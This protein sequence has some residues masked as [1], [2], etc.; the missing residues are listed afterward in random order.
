MHSSVRVY[1]DDGEYVG[2]IKVLKYK[3][4]GNGVEIEL[5]FKAARNSK[6]TDYN[7][8]QTV[9]TDHPL[10]GT[11]QTYT[12]P[13][14][15]DD[16]LPFYHT[17]SELAGMTNTSRGYNVEFYDSPNRNGVSNSWWKGE[18]SLVGRFNGTYHQL[19]TFSYGFDMRNNHSFVAPLMTINPSRR[20]LNAF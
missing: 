17:N 13:R 7:W 16:N 20:Q 18:L 4:T 2:K 8:V 10:G 6:Y 5:G 12:D 3:N 14:P 9:R 19:H 1:D 11:S 15:N